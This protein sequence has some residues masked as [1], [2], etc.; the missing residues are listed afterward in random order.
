MQRYIADAAK[1]LE[2]ALSLLH[3][4]RKLT[5]FRL[6]RFSTVGPTRLSLPALAK[7]DFGGTMTKLDAL[8]I[9]A[10][11]I[12]PILENP[13][14]ERRGFFIVKRAA[15]VLGALVLLVCLVPV[16]AA[17]LLL[18]PMFNRGSLLFIQKRM[19]KN[20]RP[21]ATIKFRTMSEMPA[22]KRGADAPLETDRITPLGQFLR[23]SRI[24]EL[25]Q[26]INVLRGE[27][28]LIGP[29]PDYIAHARH[30]LSV[31]PGYRERHCIKPGIS[32]LAQTEVGYVQ[33]VDATRT[34]VQADLRYINN[35]GFRQELWV[36]WR[37]F[38]VIFRGSGM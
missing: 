12:A 9:G 27:M 13:E 10:H 29:R 24:D 5:D 6:S 28:S 2:A 19:G 34:K 8:V 14:S 17:L 18:N 26:A 7:K 16:S 11:D 22:A 30:Y 37:T 15:D 38:V 32:G 20:C 23:K 35:L 3:I 4:K 33:G 21:F 36:V 1:F 25:P 31:I